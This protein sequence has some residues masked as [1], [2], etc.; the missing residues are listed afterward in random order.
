MS[1]SKAELITDINYYF[2]D[3]ISTDKCGDDRI[4]QAV[5]CLKT[6]S[7]IVSV[8]KWGTLI[9]NHLFFPHS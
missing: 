4:S 9:V 6:Q 5:L 7:K 1:F 2:T 8:P 3:D